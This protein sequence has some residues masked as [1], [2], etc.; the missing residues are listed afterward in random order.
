MDFNWTYL[1]GKFQPSQLVC[2]PC[3]KRYKIRCSRKTVCAKDIQQVYRVMNS[4]GLYSQGNV[5]HGTET[6]FLTENREA[7]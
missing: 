1:L 3:T 5:V 7:A 2:K 6:F 4:I